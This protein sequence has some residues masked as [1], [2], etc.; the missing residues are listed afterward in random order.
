LPLW[1]QP[2]EKLNT[3]CRS[4]F[5]EASPIEEKNPVVYPLFGRGI[6]NPCLFRRS[7]FFLATREAMKN[8]MDSLREFF[9]REQL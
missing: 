1:K 5:S 3:L 6:K 4:S 7:L 2:S 9:R 8:I